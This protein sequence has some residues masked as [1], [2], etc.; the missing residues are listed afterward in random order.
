MRSTIAIAMSG[1]VDSLVAAA[2]LKERGHNLLAVHF[3]TGYEPGPPLD[4]VDSQ[5]SWR[6]LHDQ[7][8]HRLQPLADALDI[9]LYIIDLRREF[10]N[11]VVDYFVGTYQNGR[12]PNPCLVCNPAIKFDTLFKRAQDLGATRIA[13]GHY[14]RNIVGDDGRRHLLRGVDPDKDQSYFLARLTQEQL[15]L[16]V[17]PL[18]ELTKAQTRRI[19]A[20]RSLQPASA[21]ESQDVCFIKNA[22]YG[23]F[24]S[25]QPGFKWHPGP[26]E[27]V[28]GRAIGNHKGLHHYTIGQRKGIDCPAARPYYVVKLDAP[29]NCLVV[30]HK[31]DVF[32]D[33]CRVSQ[34]NWIVQP[35]K[36][37]LEVLARVRYRHKAVAATLTPLEQ[38]SALVRFVKPEPAVTPG[39][40]AVFYMDDEVLGGGWIQ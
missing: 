11:L 1:G 33:Q 18:A 2:L 37:P 16:A 19:A 5:R 9:P 24:L 8:H 14:A 28:Q 17:F 30:G 10:K 23:D 32:A 3:I 4:D 22:R 36:A 29:R 6:Q 27:D 39:Q 13:T 40:G 34:I 7:A 35:P 21:V 38:T 31:E 20:D 25:W 26:I 12:T 15:A